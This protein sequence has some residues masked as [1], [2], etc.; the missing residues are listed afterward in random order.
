MVVDTASAWN[1]LTVAAVF[2]VDEVLIPISLE[3]G[4]S[5]IGL[6]EIRKKLD[7]IRQYHRQ[8]KLRYVLPTFLNMDIP[9]SVD[10]MDQIVPY[11]PR[12]LCTPIRYSLRI[13]ESTAQGE[14]IFE[15]APESTAA[16]DYWEL[17][18]RIKADSPA[19]D[20]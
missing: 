7:K 15:F 3:V 20:A 10:M 1:R 5:L 2:L 6:Y 4:E 13:R 19:S 8:M 16:A 18:R 9:K 14:S 12:E 11:F 17:V